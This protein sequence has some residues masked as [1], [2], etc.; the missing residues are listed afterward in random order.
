MN[1]THAER[2]AAAAALGVIVGAS[3]FLLVSVLG[4]FHVLLTNR[5]RQA[6]AQSKTITR[7]GSLMQETRTYSELSSAA[8]AMIVGTNQ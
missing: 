3:T 8:S 5:R 1:S 2:E 4:I 7:H 6:K